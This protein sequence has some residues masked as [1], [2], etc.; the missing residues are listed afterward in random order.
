MYFSVEYPNTKLQRWDM[1]SNIPTVGSSVA[2]VYSV[3]KNEEPADVLS[4]A[5]LIVFLYVASGV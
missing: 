5:F 3:Q 1:R 2:L 4:R